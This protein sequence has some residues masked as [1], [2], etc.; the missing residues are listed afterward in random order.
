M[1]GK[2]LADSSGDSNNAEEQGIKESSGTMEAVTT[3]Y[4]DRTN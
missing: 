2:K 4:D 3:T 1:I